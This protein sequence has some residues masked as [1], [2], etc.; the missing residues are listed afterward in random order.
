MDPSRF[1][2]F[3]KLD[4]EIAKLQQSRKKRQMTADIRARREH[5][6]KSRNY[7]DRHEQ[8]ARP[9]SGG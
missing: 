1:E 8:D 7:A 6:S 3:L 5:Q 4:E 9:T 2:G